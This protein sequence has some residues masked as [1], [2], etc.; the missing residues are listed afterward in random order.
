MVLLKNDGNLLPF[1]KG[2]KLALFGMGTFDYVRGGGGSR[3]RA[4]EGP[5]ELGAAAEPGHPALP[6]AAQR[7]ASS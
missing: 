7:G 5:G 2:T 4:H 6:A 3:H 1:A